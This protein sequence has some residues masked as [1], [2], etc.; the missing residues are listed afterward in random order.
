MGAEVYNNEGTVKAFSTDAL[1]ITSISIGVSSDNYY[2]ISGMDGNQPV[3]LRVDPSVFPHQAEHLLPRGSHDIYK[4]VVTSDDFVAFHALRMSDGNII[5]GEIS[6]S[7]VVTELDDIG[8]EV[9]QLVRI[10]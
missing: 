10:Q 7:G 8:T 3:L 1:G 6:P 2:Y 4:M 5:I 9:I